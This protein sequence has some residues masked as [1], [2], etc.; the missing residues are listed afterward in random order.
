MTRYILNVHSAADSR[1]I[2]N[3]VVSDG[4]LPGTESKKRVTRFYP[5]VLDPKVP[6]NA[7][8]CVFETNELLEQILLFL[9]AKNIFS[10]WRVSKQ[11]AAVIDSSIGL[12]RKMFLRP[13][14]K[15]CELWTLDV[16]HKVGAHDYG[17]DWPN[18]N[19]FNDTELKFRRVEVSPNDN[20][21]IVPITLNPM[22]QYRVAGMPNTERVFSAG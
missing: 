1:Y 19:R 18:L 12:Q 3:I 10:V 13:D 16:E 7:R 21:S 20:S 15:P 8:K 2:S 14:D 9:P 22:L 4:P 11:W 5:R 17:E 6:D